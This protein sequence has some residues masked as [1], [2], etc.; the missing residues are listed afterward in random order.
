MSRQRSDPYE[1]GPQGPLLDLLDEGPVPTPPRH[2]RGDPWTSRESGDAMRGSRRLGQ[3]QAEAHAL[4]VAH[5]GLTAQEIAEID[6]HRDLVRIARRLSELQR[7]GRIES[8]GH[9]GNSRTGRRCIRWWPV[10]GR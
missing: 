7:A 4:V 8:R 2:K 10:E 9:G 1:M 5:P 6:G 3:L